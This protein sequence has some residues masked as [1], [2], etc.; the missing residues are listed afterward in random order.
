MK[1]ILRKDATYI[2]F[3]CDK[4]AQFLC[5]FCSQVLFMMMLCASI[6]ACW[7]MLKVILNHE[8]PLYVLSQQDLRPLYNRGDVVLM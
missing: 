3:V 1:I 5:Q 6:F 2:R 7:N 4:V 8:T